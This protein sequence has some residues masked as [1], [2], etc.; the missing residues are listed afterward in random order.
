MRENR[1]SNA[2]GVEILRSSSQFQCKMHTCTRPMGV[3]GGGQALRS[4]FFFFCK[5]IYACDGPW[6]MLA[7][8][9][10]VR[11]GQTPMG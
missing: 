10:A 3:G 5:K 4:I 6:N 8:A 2:Q 9:C 11:Q 7:W 1:R